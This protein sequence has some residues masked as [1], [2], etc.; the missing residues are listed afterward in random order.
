SPIPSSSHRSSSI[1]AQSLF[2]LTDSSLGSRARP[3]L[4]S[5]R[6]SFGRRSRLRLGPR[7]GLRSPRLSF[8]R[9]PRLRL[10]SSSG[11][12]GQRGT[13]GSVVADLRAAAVE[14]RQP[15]V[16]PQTISGQAQPEVHRLQPNP[17]PLIERDSL[18]TGSLVS[19]ADQLDDSVLAL[20]A[21]VGDHVERNLGPVIIVDLGN[22]IVLARVGRGDLDNENRLGSLGVHVEGGPVTMPL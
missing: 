5:P 13:D 4:R 21:D 16:I 3:G 12:G 8:G 14:T 7:L 2:Q 19:I 20:L 1:L 9:R 18:V 17:P 6:L 22:H 15:F 10:C 11:F